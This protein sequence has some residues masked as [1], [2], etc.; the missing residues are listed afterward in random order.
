MGTVYYDAELSATG[1]DESPVTRNPYAITT[2]P[3][4]G[5]L[6]IEICKHLSVGG[7]FR[8]GNRTLADWLGYA[9][10]SQIPYLL[11]QLACDGWIN[12]D[13]DSRLIMLLRDYRSDQA[14]RSV[15][16]FLFA[17][18]DTTSD[19]DSGVID[20]IDRDIAQQDGG[21]ESDQSSRSKPQR[22]EDHVLVAAAES[23]SRSA[24]ARYKLP[25][26]DDSI[27]PTD[28]R[29]ALLSELGTA[30][31]LIA[32]ALTKRPGLTPAQIRATW[33]HFAPRIAAGLCTA[34]AFHAA[35]ANGQI[36][37][38]PPDPAAPLD[39]Q[40]YASDPAFQL[41]GDSSPPD[42]AQQRQADYADAHWRAVALLGP[43][44]PFRDMAV[45][46]DRLVS[47]DSDQAALAALEQHRSAVRR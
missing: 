3:P 34:G 17:G 9:S 10:A 22:M 29:V 41:G 15:D 12:Y 46:V 16:R 2:I 11:S 4:I 20:P 39:P 24:A 47:G 14:I 7:C 26:G 13:R 21:N 35:V 23:D 25:C 1:A 45:L 37:A 32:R 30:P 38:A 36:H 8:P 28:H 5:R 43:G 19:D 44:A 31:K 33:L 18:D 42:E 6:L 27:S 40:S